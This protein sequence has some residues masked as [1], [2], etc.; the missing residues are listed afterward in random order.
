MK[1]HK[2]ID[3]HPKNGKPDKHVYKQTQLLLWMY[4]WTTPNKNISY[5]E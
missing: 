4:T 3:G 2:K 1:R 5:N